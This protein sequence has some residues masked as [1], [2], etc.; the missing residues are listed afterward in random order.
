MVQVCSSCAAENAWTALACRHCHR[1]LGGGS[2]R[3]DPAAGQ[4]ASAAEADLSGSLGKVCRKCESYNEPGAKRCAH[5]AAPLGAQEDPPPRVMA[6]LSGRP[7]GWGNRP[8]PTALKARFV[9]ATGRADAPHEK[10][11]PSCGARN[12]AGAKFCCECGLAFPRSERP[13]GAPEE[14]PDLPVALDPDPPF[15]ASLVVDRGATAGTS[16]PLRMNNALG[17]GGGAAAFA[18]GVAA[19]DLRDDPWLAPL[20]ATVLFDEQ[21][22]LLRDEGGANG[23]YLRVRGPSSLSPGDHF[24]AGERLLRFDGRVELPAAGKGGTPYLGAPRPQGALLRVTEVLQGGGDGR[25]CLRPGPVISVG[26][27]GCD[28]NFPADAKLSARHAEIRVA[29]DGS[30]ALHDLGAAADGVF[31][32][33]REKAAQELRQGDVLLLGDQQLRVEVG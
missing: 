27:T 24:I 20:Q 11:C 30:A 2:T 26:K 12:P 3:L 14:D 6:P 16:F 13:S 18:E 31:L 23:V 7:P 22:L 19:V 28:L 5:C 15:R 17:A 9:P 10:P 29:A 33:L 1:L 21:R 8:E 32:R 4:A 25:V